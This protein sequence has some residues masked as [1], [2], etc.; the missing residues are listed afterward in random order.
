MSS[1][2]ARLLAELPDWVPLPPTFLDALGLVRLGGDLGDPGIYAAGEL[3]TLPTTA[4]TATYLSGAGQVTDTYT[5][6]LLRDLLADA[7]GVITDP[8]V[9]NDILAH[10]VVA[11]GSDGYRAVFSMGELEQRFG[12]EPVLVSYADTSG[13]LGPDGSEGWLRMIVPGDAAGGRYVSHL[14]GLSAGS[15]PDFAPGSGS[16]S[17]EFHLD[18][19]V[20]HPGTYDE[21]SLATLSGVTLTA[22]YTSGAG[23]VTDT[24]TGVPLW[25]LLQ[26]AGVLTDPA[27]K[28]DILGLYVVATGTDG[29][30]A[31]FSMG[32]LDPRFGDGKVVVAYDDTL[33][34]L[35]P[36]GND[37]FAR[38][39]VP[40]DTAGGRYISN[41]ASIQV[42]DIDATPITHDLVWG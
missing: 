25:D 16:V 21:A 29:Y 34:Q 12:N 19:A 11:T 28:N 39:V 15:G 27:V 37:G 13:Q 40:D 1:I 42:V 18:G 8:A 33:G 17:T 6:V 32:E 38:L 31:V 7:G 20:A 3:Q 9:K 10:Y 41:L 2:M 36:D 30:R 22:I 23:Q 26:S 14:V 4:E 35:G 5:G 24:Y